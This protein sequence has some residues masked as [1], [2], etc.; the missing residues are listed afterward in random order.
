MAT[1]G[2]ALIFNINDFF[3]FGVAFGKKN[4]ISVSRLYINQIGPN[5]LVNQ[6][7]SI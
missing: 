1:P 3:D 6:Q 7:F 2:L 4:T 5:I